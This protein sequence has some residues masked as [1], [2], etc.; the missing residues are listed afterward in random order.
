MIILLFLL[1]P[2]SSILLVFLKDDKKER[3]RIMNLLLILNSI[4]FFSPIFSAYLNTPKGESMWNENT[5]GGAYLWLYF[6]V[7]PLSA[8]AQLVLLILKIVFSTNSK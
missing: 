1:I 8:L 2:L 5:G 4:F 7:L 6:I 3:K